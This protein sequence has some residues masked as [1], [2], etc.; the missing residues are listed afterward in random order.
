MFDFSSLKEDEYTKEVKR[1][2]DKSDLRD[3]KERV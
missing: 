3:D 1:L 2:F